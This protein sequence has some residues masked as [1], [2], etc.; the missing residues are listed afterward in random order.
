LYLYGR[1]D[2]EPPEDLPR[3]PQRHIRAARRAAAR[4]L[5][6]E[7]GI[8]QRHDHAPAGRTQAFSA[9]IAGASGRVCGEVLGCSGAASA[10]RHAQH[11]LIGDIAGVVG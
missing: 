3:A 7:R 9:L 6:A 4:D 1:P 2:Q 8:R 11:S 10:H 5:P